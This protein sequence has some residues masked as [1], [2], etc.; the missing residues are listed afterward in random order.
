LLTGMEIVPPSRVLRCSSGLRTPFTRVSPP[1]NQV[2]ATP[3]QIR[4]GNA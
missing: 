2:P 3:T 4:L 1:P